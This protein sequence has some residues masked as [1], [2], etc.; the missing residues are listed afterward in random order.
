LSFA[1]LL[2]PQ[3]YH[4]AAVT[5][6]NGG[7]NVGVYVPLFASSNTLEFATILVTFGVMV[8]VWCLMAERFVRQK[9]IALVLTRYGHR[10][11]PLILIGLG[12]YI[13]IEGGTMQALLGLLSNHA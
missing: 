11:T 2:A 12:V 8:G 13:F 7:D 10:V 9:A 4:V 1:H 6:A 3:T 5:F